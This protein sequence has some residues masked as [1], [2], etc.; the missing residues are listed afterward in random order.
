M[1]HL[2]PYLRKFRDRRMTRTE[3]LTLHT[4]WYDAIVNGD[5]ARL[6]E[7]QFDE[8]CSFADRFLDGLEFTH[9]TDGLGGPESLCFHFINHN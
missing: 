4:V 1:G 6:T 2:A 3:S 9:V 8:F 5:F 7:Q